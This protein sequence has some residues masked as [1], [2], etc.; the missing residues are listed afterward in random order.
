MSWEKDPL[1]AKSKLYFERAFSESRDSPLF[2]LWCS[3]GLE[4]LARAALA[5]ISPTLLAEPDREHKHLLHALGRGSERGAKRSIGT[6]QVLLLCQSL[7]EEFSADDLKVATALINRRNDELHSGAAA[8]EEYPPKQWIA[9][10]YRSCKSLV[11]SMGETLEGLFGEE[12][13]K[14][15]TEM[16]EEIK[17]G[18]IGKVK[19][20]IAAHQKVFT[21]KPEKEQEALQKKAEEEG[22]KLAFQRH[23]RV[24]C[25]AC[26]SVAT[27]QGT[28]FGKERVKNEE[29]LVIVSQAVSPN[30]FSCLAC[31]LKLNGYAELDAAEMGGHY[32]RTTE[33]SPEEYYGLIHPD[34]VDPADYIDVDEYMRNYMSDYREYDN[35]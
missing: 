4:L 32:T 8:F 9:G 17:E 13:A 31:G 23:H 12:E 33:Y 22:N 2:G 25:P 26:G 24:D 18:V 11:L 35:E 10:F 27:V 15:A 1:W 16:L 30:S 19:S 21:G 6:A 20:A 34:D 28:P 3:L 7:F 29:D 14:A 5:S